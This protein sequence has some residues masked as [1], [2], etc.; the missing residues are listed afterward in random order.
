MKEFLIQS[1]IPF[2]DGFIEIPSWCKRVKIDVGL[3]INAHHSELWLTKDPATIIFG[4]EP[5]PFNARK[6]RE[7]SSN[8]PIMLN[9]PKYLNKNFFLLECALSDIKGGGESEFFCTPDGGCSSLLEPKHFEVE[10]VVRV[11]NWSLNDFLKYF[12]FNQIPYI[13]FVKTDCQGADFGVIKGCSEYLEKIAVFTCEADNWRY[14]KSKNSKRDITRFFED[15]QFFKLKLF[16]RFVR[17]QK[18]TKNRWFNRLLGLKGF[19]DI[20]TEDPTYVNSRYIQKL[21]DDGVSIFQ[22]G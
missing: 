6:V 22:K 1:G 4:F 8:T 12:P 10:A 15:R 2:K 9:S 19:E 3:S 21:K 17:L 16:N 13:D 18:F 5:N 11:A 7:R 14:H 20:Y